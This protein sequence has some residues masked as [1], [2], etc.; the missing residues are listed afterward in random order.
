[1]DNKQII[2]NKDLREMTGAGIV[3]C[4][5]AL[6]EAGGSLTE[7]EGILR[8]RGQKIVD[9]KLNREANEGI[10]DSYVHANNKIGVLLELVCE[11]D[12]V[13]R[14]EKFRELAHNLAMQVAAANPQWIKIA[15]IP[16]D[17]VE[18]EKEI[19]RE[20]VD[21]GKQAQVREKII[22][23]RLQKFYS[24]ACL[25]EQ[26]FIKDDKVII[27]D[28]IKE[29]IVKLGENIRIKRFIRFEI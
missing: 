24:Q 21:K 16:P 20:G 8:K 27:K 4:Q 26:P 12:F 5:K 1:M 15:D 25:E 13:A 29:E 19:A 2:K 11:T 9:K 3:E 23:G 7:A 17:V 18:K 22:E 10:V 6:E 14:N 28:L